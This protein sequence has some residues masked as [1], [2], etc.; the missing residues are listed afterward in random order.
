MKSYSIALLPGDG[1][2]PEVVGAAVALLR[3]VEQRF[4]SFRLECE[5]LSVGAGEYLRSGD[6]L[7]EPTYRRLEQFDAILLGAMGLPDV[8]WPNGTEM[9]PQLDLRE[10]MEL[11]A[12][13]RPIKLYHRDF[14]PLKGYE[15]G[16]I[17]F[18]ILRENTEGLFHSRKGSL[19]ASD[20]E[21]IDGM[22]ISRKGSE[23]LFRT[24]FEQARKRRGKVTLVDKS[25]VLPSLAFFRQIFGEIAA[26]NPDVETEK[27]YIDAST[28]YLVQRPETFDV[29]VTENMFGDILSDLAAGLVGGMGLA[30]S[31]D[32][33]DE[34]AVFQPSHGSAPD[35]AGKGWANPVATILSAAMMLE[36]LGE[37]EAA[38]VIELAVETVLAAPENRTR[39][40]KGTLSCE[41]MGRRVVEAL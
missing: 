11:Y 28:L 36:W 31:G 27:I 39:D 33:G 5:Q 1:I 30:P 4:D 26:E 21:M 20:E 40:L 35:I 8:R 17:D 23:R 7:P 19:A 34:H 29:I 18:V 37:G 22:R 15:A 12:G 14:T 6:P 3:A 9:A 38:R 41:E 2:G 24:A 13:L 10:R 16:E 32:V 25:N